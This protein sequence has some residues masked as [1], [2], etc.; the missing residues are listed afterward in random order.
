VLNEFNDIYFILFYYS[1]GYMKKIGR[2]GKIFCC[3]FF[4]FLLW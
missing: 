4:F 3:F 1:F 2:E